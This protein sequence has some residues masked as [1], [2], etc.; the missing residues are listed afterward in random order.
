MFGGICPASAAPE[1]INSTTR[2]E[3]HFCSADAV[4]LSI[5]LANIISRRDEYRHNR[6]PLRVAVGPL[7]LGL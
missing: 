1:I 5:A 6:G 3:Y 2:D 4:H 7:S